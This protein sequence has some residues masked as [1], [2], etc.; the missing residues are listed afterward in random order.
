MN[1]DSKIFVAGHKG[2]VGSGITRNLQNAGFTNLILKTRAE[3]ILET[4]ANRDFF[5][6]T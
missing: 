6:N 3:L 1:K 4:K 5:S 2:L